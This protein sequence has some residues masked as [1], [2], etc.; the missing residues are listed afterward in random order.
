[1]YIYQGM[2]VPSYVGLTFKPELISHWQLLSYLNSGGGY[3]ENSQPELS[4]S[5]HSHVQTLLNSNYKT[6]LD[7]II[8][9]LLYHTSF[10][11]MKNGLVTAM[12]V[13]ISATQVFMKVYSCC[14]QVMC[15]WEGGGGNRVTWTLG[16]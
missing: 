5:L 8:D 11:Q 16:E 1:M 10:L 15:V 14:M 2:Q 7:C 12:H 4:A 6:G 13:H 9:N 3:K